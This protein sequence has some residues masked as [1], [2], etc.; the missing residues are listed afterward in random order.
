[1]MSARLR[2]SNGFAALCHY[3]LDSDEGGRLSLPSALYLPRRDQD[4]GVLVM[5]VGLERPV[6]ITF[7]PS[8]GEARFRFGD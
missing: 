3:E 7:E 2:L 8:W 5:G 4:E 1:M 6:V